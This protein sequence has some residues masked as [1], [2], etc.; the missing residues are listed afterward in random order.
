M[1]TTASPVS[2]NAATSRWSRGPSSVRHSDWKPKKGLR[3]PKVHLAAGMCQ[4]LRLQ[5]TWSCPWVRS[6]PV[7]FST[8]IDS[9]GRQHSG[10]H[11]SGLA[12]RG[13]CSRR[14]AL[15]S[16]WVPDLFLDRRNV[17]SELVALAGVVLDFDGR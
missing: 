17:A 14:P 1:A 5:A 8:A 7:R 4:R 13:G 3:D 9:T 12:F 11:C 10:R 15:A 16:E 6:G 2:T